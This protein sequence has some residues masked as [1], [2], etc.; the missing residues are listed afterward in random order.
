M[1]PIPVPGWNRFPWLR[2]GF[3]TR[4]GGLS[5]VYGPGDLNLGLTQEDEPATVRANR[6]LLLDALDA[7]IPAALTPENWQSTGNCPP[8]LAT[9]RQIHSARVLTV[10]QPGPA[11]EGDGLLT[12][13]PGLALG[14]LTADCTPVLIADTRRRVVAA[15]HAG[16]RGTVAAIVEQGVAALYRDFGSASEDLVAAV[17]PAIGACCY[18]VGEEVHS[19]FTDR[20]G[21]APLLFRQRPDGLHLDLAE[22]NRRQLLSCG[23]P[24][25]NI[26]LT[27]ECTACARLPS[28]DTAQ[29]GQRTFFSHRAEHGF[30]GRMM[31]IIAIA[32]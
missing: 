28:Q 24:A 6:G 3:S 2:H 26:T 11:G 9:L 17:G 12:A 19:A 23:V 20:F 18:T 25:E 31:S 30:T 4:P 22:A 14:I 15:F 13:I 21:Y 32:P 16:W 1:Q 5:T 10:S 8:N 29:P 27:G 7:A